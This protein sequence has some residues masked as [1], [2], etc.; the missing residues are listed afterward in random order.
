[1]LQPN[2]GRLPVFLSLPTQR[3]PLRREITNAARLATA[4]SDF[5]LLLRPPQAQSDMCFKLLRRPAFMLR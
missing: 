5:N 1:M 2:M 3:R 4:A